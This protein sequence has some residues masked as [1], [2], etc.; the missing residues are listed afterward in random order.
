MKLSINKMLRLFKQITLVN[1]LLGTLTASAQVTTSSPYSEFGLGDLKGGFP[2]TTAMGGISM[3]VRKMGS[4]YNMINTANPA[5]YS[6]IELTAFD[7]G[8]FI[9]SRELSQGSAS[10]KNLNIGLSHIAL[11]MPVSKKSA[12]SFGLLPYSEMGYLN[13]RSATLT[14]ADNTTTAIDYVHTGDGGLS[15]VYLGYGFA[16][17]PQFSIGINAAYLFGSLKQSVANEFPNDPTAL[18]SRE[19]N[20]NSI[21]APVLDYGVQYTINTANKSKVTIGYAGTFVGDVDVVNSKTTSVYRKDFTSGNESLS[22]N[23]PYTFDDASSNW[24]IPMT[25]SL[26]FTFEKTNKLILGADVR[27]SEWSSFRQAATNPGLSNSYAIAAG[28]QITPDINAIGNYLKLIDYRF[29]VKYDKTYIR[30]DDQGIDQY[31]VTFG[32]GLPLKS[33]RLAV[34]KINFA[35]EIGKRGSLVNGLVRENYVNF[36]LGFTLNDKWFI[37]S[38]FD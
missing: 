7:I 4:A 30:I 25:H 18:N 19:D 14:N 1:I 32:L 28:G 26:G 33:N 9:S 31:A 36:S 22:L 6:S 35:T 3:G 15:K 21:G 23:A 13:K 37:K 8:T 11:A 12:L 34:Y 20:L 16:I 29:G 27:Y 17:T 38:K 10:G 24:T 5:S 2:Q